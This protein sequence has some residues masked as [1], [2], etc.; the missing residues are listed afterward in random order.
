MARR[1]SNGWEGVQSDAIGTHEG[2]ETASK[3]KTKASTPMY[4]DED[5]GSSLQLWKSN[6]TRDNTY[7]RRKRNACMGRNMPKLVEVLSCNLD[8]FRISH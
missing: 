8:M 6:M 3:A 4:V 7:E 1:L 5:R 2:K